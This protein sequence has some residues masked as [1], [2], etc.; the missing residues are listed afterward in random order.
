MLKNGYFKRHLAVNLT[1][2]KAE[3]LELDDEFLER[4][5]GGRGFGVRYLFENGPLVDP[6]SP[7]NMLCSGRRVNCQTDYLRYCGR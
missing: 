3:R 5:I 1:D 7:E 2:R 6:L 4:Y